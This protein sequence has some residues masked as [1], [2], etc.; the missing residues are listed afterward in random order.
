[1]ILVFGR[2][3]QIARALARQTWSA[4]VLLLG[5]KEIDVLNAAALENVIAANRPDFIINAAAYTAV[6]KAETEKSQA[7]ALNAEFPAL[8]GQLS[9]RFDIPLIHFSTDYVFAGSSDRPWLETDPYEPLN[10]YG[11]S[12]RAGDEAILAAKCPALVLRVSW[13]FSEWGTNFVKTIL[14][15]AREREELKI[16]DDQRGTPMSAMMIGAL[17]RRLL[18][19]NNLARFWE[20]SGVYHL[21][22]PPAV[23]WFEFAQNIIECARTADVSLKLRSLQPIL[24]SEFPTPAKR[25]QQSAMD[26]SRFQRVFLDQLG[27]WKED[28]PRVVSELTTSHAVEG[29]QICK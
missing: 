14:R 2:Q 1:M 8:L 20:N 25:P 23:S 29:S 21:S 6:D 17:V 16:V 10:E 18:S 11:K 7:W 22:S 13:V 24:S 5:S 27:S 28:L 4:P 15:L 9:R 19:A 12:K 26:D 3:G